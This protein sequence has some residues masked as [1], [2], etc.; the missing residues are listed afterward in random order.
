[1]TF[2]EIRSKANAEWEKLEHSTAT[3]LYI[4]TSTWGSAAGATEILE[5]LKAELKEQKIEAETI[6]V[7]SLG[8]KYLEPVVCIAKPGQPRIFYGNMTPETASQLVKD[9][10]QNDNP[11]PDLAFG[12][13]GKGEIAGLPAIA[14]L[15]TM[16]QQ[17]RIILRNCGNI[18]PGN[19]YHYIAAGGYA[20]L[21]K[22]LQMKPEE[23]IEEIKKS[24]LKGRGGAGFLTGTKWQ[25]CHDASGGEKYLICNADE[26]DPSAFNGRLLLEGDPHSVLEGMLIAAYAA[27][28]GR[29]YIYIN[30]G[31][32]IAIARLENALKQMRDSGLLGGNIAG[33]E[34]SFDIE[35]RKGVGAFVCGEETALVRSMEGRRGMPFVRPP[36]PTTTGL[37]GKPTVVNDVETLASAAVILQKDANWFAGYGSSQSKGT[38]LITLSG[39]VTY[40]GLIEVPLGITLRQI[41]FD[42]GGGIPN[43]REFKAVQVGGP[44]GGCLPESALDTPLDFESLDSVGAIM[45]S[46]SI[47]VADNDDCVVNLA[48]DLITFSQAQSCGQCIFCR[49]GTIQ[50]RE[51][52]KD[53]TSGES[54]TDDIELLLDLGGA[55]KLG[56]LCGLGK[57]AANPVLTSINNFRDE[58]T[59]HVSRKRCPAKA[60]KALIVFYIQPGNCQG[61]TKCL[62]EC[63]ANAITGGEKM[64][65]IIDQGK[66]TKCGKCL[67]VCPAEYNAV[68]RIAGGRPPALPTEPVP[69]GSW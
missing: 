19:I 55:M 51:F 21:V 67:E 58:Y 23:I 25:E 33:S 42:I 11:R 10:L 45:G 27:G 3:R 31:Y 57:T 64:I 8:F 46:G 2:E 54:K 18:D 29:G 34:F 12:T 4:D 17:V 59:A 32:Y 16:K 24:G 15:P 1:M 41:I 63:P 65:H 44:T 35:L 43:G 39:K 61:C 36:Y 26:G 22:A 40:P 66:C 13:N 53:I 7:G 20:G 50:M 5:Y 28:A 9:Y 48:K 14:D 38:K 60:C 37:N 47:V 69:V 56:S 52:L 6:E 62:Q 30:D 49:E 68:N